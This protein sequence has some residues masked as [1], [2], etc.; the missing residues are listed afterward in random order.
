[1]K[2]L[3]SNYK[4]TPRKTRLIADRI[5]GKFVS[6]ALVELSFLNR[7]GAGAIKKLLESAVSNAK[8]TGDFNAD[9]L[10]VKEVRVDKGITFKRFFP[11]SRGMAHPI[12]RTRSRIT[13]KLEPANEIKKSAHQKKNTRKK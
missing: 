12:H 9:N 2:A 13:I 6:D 7:K 1:M 10:R 3:L 8:Q 5:R 4:Q 11:V